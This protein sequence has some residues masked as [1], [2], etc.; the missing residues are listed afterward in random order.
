MKV[1]II[2]ATGKVGSL[3]LEEA[4]NRGLDVT[5]IVRNADKLNR[6]DVSVIEKGINDLTTDD[7]KAFDVVVSAFGARTNAVEAFTKSGRHLIDILSNTDVRLIVVGGAGS[8]YTD[9]SKTLRVSEQEG[10]PEAV[11]PVAQGQRQN[12]EDFQKA[13]DLTWTFVSPSQQFDAEGPRTGTYQT[14][15]D[16]AQVNSQG[17]SYV[18]YADFAIA[19]VDEIEQAQ[20][21]NERFTVV[22]EQA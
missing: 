11:K 19:I 8:L 16:V 15:K 20:H 2:S 10:F 22:S 17:N 1:G 13:S 14:G 6:Q 18:S 3:V 7:I 4:L 5:A 21:I 12:L 9:E